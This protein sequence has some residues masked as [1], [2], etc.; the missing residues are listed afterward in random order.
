MLKS[1]AT[2]NASRL[3]ILRI[4]PDEFGYG[5][6]YPLFQE[7]EQHSAGIMRTFAFSDRSFHVRGRDGVE[8]VAGQLISGQYFAAL[9]LRPQIGR[10][11]EPHDDRP[12]APD[13]MVAV[14]SDHFWR[15]QMGGDP[16]ALGQKITVNQVLFTIV[17]VMPKAFRGMSRDRAPDVF[18]PLQLEPNVDAPF[19]LFA[20]G[21]RAWWLSTGAYLDDGVSLEQANAFLRAN[22]RHFFN[23][24]AAG[25]ALRLNGHKLQELHLTAEPGV[26]GLSYLRLRF[27]KPL[28]VLMGLVAMV[29]L[30]ACLNLATLLAVRAASRSREISTRFAL[31]ASRTRLMRQLVTE[32]SL[33]AVIGAVLGLSASPLLAHFLA[34]MLTPQHGPLSASL[35]VSPDLTVFVYTALLAVTATV[36]AGALPAIRSTGQELHAVMRKSSNSI[37]GSERRQWWPSL[38]LAM[39]VGLSLILVTGASLLGYSL[40]K[41]HQT[42]MGF[43][44]QGLVYLFTENSKQ[45]LAGDRL[46][47][48]YKQILNEIRSLPNVQDASVS[49]GVPLTGDG[50]IEQDIQAV[51]G[52]KHQCRDFAVGLDY[53]KT[54]RTPLLSGREF[55]WTDKDGSGRKV[56]LNRSAARQLFPRVDALGQRVIFEDGKTQGEVVGVVGDSKSANL[57]DAA[58]PIV[59][60][61]AVQNLMPGA[62]LAILVRTKGS[63][64]PLIAAAGKVLRRVVPDIPAPAAM[65]MEETIAESLVTERIMAALALFFGGVALLI[66]GIGLYGTLAY[67]TE[68]RTGEIGIRLA[69]GAQPRRIISMVCAENGLVA[70]MGCVAGIAGSLFASRTIASFLFGVSPHD[71]AVL[72]TAAVLLL[73]VAAGASLVPAVQ[74]ALMDPLAA[75]RHE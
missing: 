10:W 27:R 24:V 37:R 52:A 55:Q 66:T 39:Q 1:V 36:L 54:L 4:R 59:Y 13:G 65:S 44:P 60:S 6:C 74:A 33:L 43:E 5:L 49:A 42:P 26:N 35:D 25:P 20:A 67:S 31:G 3:A 11:I 7:L 41:L 63:A 2:P 14:V 47:V 16:R 12:G 28:T 73:S 23:A 56:I 71:P 62:S 18:L 19:N 15:S 46:L 75:I 64:T 22:P 30:I 68:R 29:L 72:I 32:S 34:S 51:G 50:Y 57:R 58:P 17:G 8:A 48:T 38:F 61:P 53:F 45:P 9:G 40:V 70:V 21:Y 69:L